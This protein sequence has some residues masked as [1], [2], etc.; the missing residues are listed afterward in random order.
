MRTLAGI[1]ALVA[2]VVFPMAMLLWLSQRL[3]RQP[4][5]APART[6]LLLALNGILPVGLILAGLVLLV[7]AIGAAPAA[8]IGAMICLAA[9]AAIALVLALQGRTEA[10]DD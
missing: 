6:G 10:R 9:A 4:S 1:L 8:R 5:L 7:P 3:N 2:G